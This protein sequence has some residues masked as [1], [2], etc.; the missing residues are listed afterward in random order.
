MMNLIIQ[1]SLYSRKYSLFCGVGILFLRYLE[2]CNASPKLSAAKLA[3]VAPLKL[4]L[5]EVPAIG[6]FC[7]DFGGAFV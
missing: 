6:L 1:K 5:R 7:R 4:K 3:Q 2:T